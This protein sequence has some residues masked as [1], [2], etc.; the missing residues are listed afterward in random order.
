[1]AGS[2]DE[3]AEL[4]V[5]DLLRPASRRCRSLPATGIRQSSESEA[6]SGEL[7]RLHYAA[8]RSIMQL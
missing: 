3:L 4:P 6:P 5:D 8:D 1:M 2:L 7:Q